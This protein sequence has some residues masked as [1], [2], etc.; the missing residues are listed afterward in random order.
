MGGDFGCVR[1][2]RFTRR[3]RHSIFLPCTMSDEDR[4]EAYSAR[5]PK[6]NAAFETYRA[7][8]LQWM[9]GMRHAARRCTPSSSLAWLSRL[10]RRARHVAQNLFACKNTGRREGGEILFR[11]ATIRRKE[12]RKKEERRRDGGTRRRQLFVGCG[13][14]PQSRSGHTVKTI[15]RLMHI[16]NCIQTSAFT[17]INMILA[18]HNYYRYMM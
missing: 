11:S 12:K 2:G 1:F 3:K 13:N 10:Q 5:A 8:R 6:P 16:M 7:I 4:N 18:T 14:S 9:K 15:V 17:S